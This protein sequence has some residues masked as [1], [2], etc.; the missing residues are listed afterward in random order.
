MCECYPF[1][2]YRYLYYRIQE[3]GTQNNAQSAPMAAATVTTTVATVAAAA[4]TTVPQHH[5]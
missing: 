2:A 5:R 3:R 1:V 4:A